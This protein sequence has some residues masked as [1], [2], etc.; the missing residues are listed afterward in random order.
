MLIY[1]VHLLPHYGSLLMIVRVKVNNEGKAYFLII[2][3]SEP[4]RA[5]TSF[6][7][8]WEEEKRRQPQRAERVL[9][10]KSVSTRAAWSGSSYGGMCE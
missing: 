6:V 8:E 7:S 4:H 9:C 5:P 10:C 1:I 3:S 2:F